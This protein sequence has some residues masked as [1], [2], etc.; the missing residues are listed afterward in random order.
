MKATE[1]LTTLVTS[2]LAV[3]ACLSE[4]T[5]PG[6]EV[7]SETHFLSACLAN[8]ECRSGFV[9][10]CGVC[11]TPCESS[12]QTGACAPGDAPAV[13]SWCG[14]ALSTGL[15]LPACG[16]GTTCEE[17][18]CEGGFCSAGPRPD[19][20]RCED[21]AQCE[22]GTCTLGF[23]G[24]ACMIPDDACPAGTYCM[25]PGA[26][27]G[28]CLPGVLEAFPASIVGGTILL[29]QQKSIELALA[30]RVDRPIEIISVAVETRDWTEPTEVTVAQ[31]AP[32]PLSPGAFVTVTVLIEP[33]RIG[34]RPYRLVIR[35]SETAPPLIVEVDFVGA[36]P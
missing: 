29:G 36:A 27:S 28:V 26:A 34:A 32:I 20:T 30:G 15:C 5:P 25:V 21:A 23:C 2:A 12:C 1:L 8:D 3:G 17:G 24:E 9:C 7:G 4:T 35:S 11:T 22:G 10:L 31:A 16:S 33:S 14:G 18:S 19:G 6:G 13:L